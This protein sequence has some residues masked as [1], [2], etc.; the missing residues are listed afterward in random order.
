M[1][2]GVVG[3]LHCSQVLSQSPLE[4]SQRDEIS[5][6]ESDAPAMARAFKKARDSLDAFLRLAKAPPPNAET[7]AV[8]V[9]VSDSKEKEYFWI[10]PFSH[11]GA[12]F[13]GRLNNTPRLVT[14]VAEG[15]EIRFKKSEIVDWMYVDTGKRRMYGNFTAC[16]LLTKETPEQ[17]AEF[18][19]HYGL[20][21]D[22]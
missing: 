10:S 12:V 4:K 22:L 15:Q 3:L 9:A 20:E 1:A 19:R 8:K 5:R 7:F 21:C 18:R 11:D 17:A 16:A 14:N 13:R 6:M 2:L